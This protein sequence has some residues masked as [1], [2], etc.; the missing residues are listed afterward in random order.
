[1]CR[2]LSLFCAPVHFPPL[3]LTRLRLHPP[4]GAEVLGVKLA[5][6]LLHFRG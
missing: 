4:F 5:Y 6:V 2:L 3:G 1:M